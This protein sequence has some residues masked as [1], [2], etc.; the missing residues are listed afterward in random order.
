[1]STL[2][3]NLV[4]AVI[5]GRTADV[6]SMLQQSNGAGVNYCNADG[7]SLLSRAVSHGHTDIA[8]LLMSYGRTIH[9][10]ARDRAG[11]TALHRACWHLPPLA[12]LQADT[13]AAANSDEQDPA[14]GNEPLSARSAASNESL[15]DVV[16]VMATPAPPKRKSVVVQSPLGQRGGSRDGSRAKEVAVRTTYV[17]PDP[18]IVP[19]IPVPLH[20]APSFPSRSARSSARESARSFPPL[21]PFGNSHTAVDVIV[22]LLDLGAQYDDINPTPASSVVMEDAITAAI[23]ESLLCN[24]EDEDRETPEPFQRSHSMADSAA[25][26]LQP[27]MSQDRTDANPHPLQVGASLFPFKAGTGRTPLILASLRGD[28][29]VAKLLVEKGADVGYADRNGLTAI[30]YAAYFGNVELVRY[31]AACQSESLE[32]DGRATLRARQC[33]MAG[34]SRA[35]TNDDRHDFTII[36]SI[37][38]AAV[39]SQSQVSVR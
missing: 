8:M 12:T 36:N 27:S 4:D 25:E 14:M 29:A 2:L 9:V 38:T 16:E 11:F 21:R 19:V 23:C 7:V 18:K 24:P 20:R 22:R 37:L 35:C 34:S 33:A 26:T 39:S 1:M 30:D 6:R 13:N 5:E 17:A 3:T 32:G 10:N 28:V 15:P 31:L